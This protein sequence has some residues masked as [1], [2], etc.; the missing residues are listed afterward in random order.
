MRFKASPY[1]GQSGLFISYNKII[2]NVFGAID[3]FAFGSIFEVD[4]LSNEA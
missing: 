1:I 3:Y 4:E 2:Y